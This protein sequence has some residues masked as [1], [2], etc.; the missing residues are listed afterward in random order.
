MMTRRVAATIVAIVSHRGAVTA[1][2]RMRDRRAERSTDGSESVTLP[3]K[4]RPPIP[5]AR[6]GVHPRDRPAALVLVFQAARNTPENMETSAA[7]HV[8][9][10]ARSSSLIP[11]GSR[12][13][14]PTAATRRRPRKM[15]HDECV[16]Q[17]DNRSRTPAGGA[18]DAKRI[19]RA[20]VK[21]RHLRNRLGC[22]AADVSR[23]SAR[24]S[25][26]SEPSS[27]RLAIFIRGV[28]ST[29]IQASRIRSSRSTA[30]KSGEELRPPRGG[31]VEGARATQELWRTLDG[32]AASPR[33]TPWPARTDDGTSITKRTYTGCRSGTDVVWY[34]IAGGGHRCPPPRRAG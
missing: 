29:G 20:G 19:P 25:A 34:E 13:T 1:Q 24:S 33:V 2:R 10:R 12:R 31:R 28:R 22:E 26:R 21:R 5:A 3:F 17:G 14:G 16:R 6:P 4:P 23:Q 32:C 9:D 11:K 18:I 8:A 27:R 15:G 7:Q 30:V